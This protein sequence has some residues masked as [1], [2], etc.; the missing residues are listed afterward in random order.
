MATKPMKTVATPVVTPVVA[1]VVAPVS[2]PP[3][4]ATPFFQSMNFK[5]LVLILMILICVGV[6]F[7]TKPSPTTVKPIVKTV[8]KKTTTTR[9]RDIPKL[10]YNKRS[11]SSCIPAER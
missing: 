5:I 11:R 2:T 6:Y 10:F 7:A 3:G 1:P 8:P 4:G 9:P